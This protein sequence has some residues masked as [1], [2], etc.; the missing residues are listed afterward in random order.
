MDALSS[1]LLSR[2]LDGL[3]LRFAYLSQNIANANTPNYAPVRVS[4]EDGLRAAMTH[5]AD[6]V[7]A[8]H[9]QLVSEAPMNGAQALRVDLELASASQTAMRY[10]ALIDLLGRQFALERAAIVGG[11]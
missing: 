4:F 2:S 9:P 8:S 11:R 3:A 6:A 5:G 7:R 10:R 1:A